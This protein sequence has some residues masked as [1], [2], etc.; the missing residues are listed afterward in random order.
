MQI[1]NDEPVIVIADDEEALRSLVETYARSANLTAKAYDSASLAVEAIDKYLGAGQLVGVVTDL[2]WG[3]RVSGWDILKHAYRSSKS[4]D[5]A[6]YTGFPA[7]EFPIAAG[8][9][10]PAFTLFPKTSVGSESLAQW[11]LELRARWDRSIGLT[12]RDADTRLIYDT[13]APIY[14]QSLLPL[15]ILGETGTGKESLAR[16]IHNKS[17]NKNGPLVPVNCGGIEPSLAFSEL[18]GH[19][20]GAFTDARHH[21]LGKMLDASGYQ[22]GRRDSR[23]D[24]QS[25]FDWLQ[26][27]N[28]DLVE[29]SGPP[30]L[31]HSEAAAKRAGTIFLDE[32]ATLP[33]NVMAG[34]LRVLETGDI[35]PFGYHGIGIRSYCRV[36][37]ATNE[38][39]ILRASTPGSR[40]Q[41]GTFRRDLFFRLAG[42]ILSLTPLRDR[43]SD[44]IRN[45]VEEVVWSQLNVSKIPVDPAALEHIVALYKERVDSVAQQYQSGNFRSLRNLAYRASLIA[46]AEN[47]GSIGTK[48]VDLAIRHG[49]ITVPDA[50]V[51]N[52]IRHIREEFRNILLEHNV[53]FS[54]EHFS[55]EELKDVTI[56]TPIEVGRAFL[57]CCLLRRQPPEKKRRYYELGEVQSALSGGMSSY[58]WLG[59]SLTRDH[60]LE[61]AIRHFNLVA[62]DCTGDKIKD[63]V[64]KIQSLVS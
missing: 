60:V 54:E 14:A 40:G 35:T 42:A 9:T 55:F 62:S 10:V 61:A 45:F 13:I 2:R 39:G 4:L 23:G 11:M 57:S 48:H 25:F 37:S 27:A 15:L 50:S 32:V 63:I 56:A 43:N 1:T 3:N 52:Q 38:V 58:A 24:S 64:R 34:L 36:I 19:T 28:P 46:R 21:E 53:K 47:A 51:G 17:N 31:L 29:R 59:K 49:E 30:R 18:F 7:E 20:A 26:E 8:E 6:V 22:M 44:D 12:L 41:Q 16:A 5:L 33:A